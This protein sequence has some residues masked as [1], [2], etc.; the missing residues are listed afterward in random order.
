MRDFIETTVGKV[1][2]IIF[3]LIGFTILYHV[4]TIFRDSVVRE[5]RVVYVKSEH[6]YYVKAV[7]K[8]GSDFNTFRTDD[9]KEAVQIARELNGDLRHDRGLAK[10]RSEAHVIR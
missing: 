3:A 1:W 9:G 4:S 5:Y 2:M 10:M 7:V 6:A 8:H